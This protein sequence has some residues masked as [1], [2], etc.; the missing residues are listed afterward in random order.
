MPGQEQS[1]HQVAG[2]NPGADG[3]FFLQNSTFYFFH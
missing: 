3:G 1:G 2:S